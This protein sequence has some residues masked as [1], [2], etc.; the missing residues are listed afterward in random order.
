MAEPLRNLVAHKRIEQFIG[1][2][3]NR[4]RNWVAVQN[5]VGDLDV[6]DRVD[7]GP[8]EENPHLVLVSYSL[9]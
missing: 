5:E 1:A 7:W 3:C 9:S 2:I 4:Y 6:V 8:A